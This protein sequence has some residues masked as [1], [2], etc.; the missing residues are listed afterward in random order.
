MA[1]GRSSQVVNEPPTAA[2]SFSSV[3]LAAS[4][5]A[6]ASTDGD[7]TVDSYAWVFGDGTTGTGASPNHTYAAGGT[8]NVR[9]TV[10]DDDGAASAPLTRSVTV[11]A[12]VANQ[13]PTAAFSFSSVGLTASF[14][15]SASTDGDGTVDSYAWVFGDGTTGTG[16]SPNHTYAAVAPTT[17]G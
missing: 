15:A 14:D 11:T 4:F 13:P 9:L 5:D 1:S 2:F 6:S 16:A 8:Y 10:T 3:G 17:C 7:G 12:P